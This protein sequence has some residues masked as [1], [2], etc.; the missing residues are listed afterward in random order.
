MSGFWLGSYIALWV[1]I[2]MLS[3]IVMGLLRQLGLIQL[4][5]GPEPGV[6]L[7]REGLERGTQAPDFEATN[8]NSNEP[9]R[10]GSLRGQRTVLVFVSP[11][12]FS[13]RQLA[14]HLNEVRRN[15]EGHTHIVTIC[16]GSQDTCS[17]FRAAYRLETPLLLDATNAIGK[18]YNVNMTPFAYL[19]DEN[20]VVRIRG[21]VNSWPQLEALIDEEGTPQSGQWQAVTEGT[22]LVSTDGSAEA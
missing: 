17:E 4:R 18:S 7:T 16:Y 2:V 8:L 6:L 21:V 5:L 10:L 9:M 14:P 19:I 12:C 1:I 3:V 11:T 20:G 13:C 22:G 15:Q